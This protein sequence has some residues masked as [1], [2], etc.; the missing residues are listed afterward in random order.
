MVSGSR[1]N[2]P[3]IDT[4]FILNINILQPGYMYINLYIKSVK[5]FVDV[6]SYLSA[7]YSWRKWFY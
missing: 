7:L 5:M 3:P 4:I 1:D 2:P 6:I